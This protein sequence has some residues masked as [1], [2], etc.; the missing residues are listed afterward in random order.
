MNNNS[1]KNNGSFHGFT[2]I[3]LL[4]VIAII[5]ILAAILF[6]VFATAREKAK[7]SACSSN[8]KQIGI[9][10]L[11]Y[12]QDYDEVYPI[13]NGG[14]AGREMYPYVKS[15]DAFTCPSD[16]LAGDAIKAAITYPTGDWSS[17]VYKQCAGVC[18]EVSY[19]FNGF[20]NTITSPL[21]MSSFTSPAKT[22]L[23][24]ELSGVFTDPSDPLEQ[25]SLE[26][27]SGGAGVPR[28]GNTLAT[29]RRIYRSYYMGWCGQT[30][31]QDVFYKGSDNTAALNTGRHSDG[32]NYLACDGHVKWLKPS[33]TS[34][35]K[36]A[37]APDCDMNGGSATGNATCGS[38]ASPAQ[39]QWKAAGT[40][41]RNGA[42]PVT[43]TFSYL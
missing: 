42:Q 31:I 34:T 36:P 15:K 4:V 10:F 30:P 26:D 1:T 37:A 20:S 18:S 8:Q 24:F 39:Y 3:E 7:M 28:G 27:Q 5:G 16:P 38:Y 43:L 35:G 29:N 22:V 25:S 32:A 41:G 12:I 21:Q 17:T 23:L 2:L 13:P 14:W 40:S 6:P 9:A 11:Q 33:L 19:G